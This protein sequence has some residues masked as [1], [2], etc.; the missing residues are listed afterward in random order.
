MTLHKM[1]P[2]DAAWFHMDGPA[3]LAM[4]TSVALTRKPLDFA[5]VKALYAARLSDYPRFRQTGRRTRVAAAGAALGGHAQLRHRPASAPRG[6]AAARRPAALAQLL[7]DIV[8]TPLDRLQPLW[9]V[10]V[11]DGVEGGSALV[12]RFHHC[13][14]DGTAMTALSM[15]LYDTDRR[16]AG[17]PARGR[18][19]EG[20]ARRDRRLVRLGLR[21]P[22]GVGQGRRVD[23]ERG[24]RRRRAPAGPDRQGRADRR[25]RGHAADRT[26]Q[27]RRPR[28]AVQGPVLAGQARRLVGAGGD[29][30]CQ[31]HRRAGRCEG[32]RRARRRHDGCAACLPEGTR[33]RRGADDAARD[34]AGRPA[35]AGARA[36][37][38]QR[39]R[40]RAA[41]TGGRRPDAARAA[42]RDQGAHGRAEAL[43]RAGGDAPAVRHL[44]PHAEAGVRHPLVDAQPARRAWS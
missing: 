23:G 33:C 7:S 19:A 5:K 36:R 32:Q 44:R 30:R 40:P 41:R 20:R 22:G 42:A 16:R 37:A 38:R 15:R 24:A 25:G 34:G 21:R 4:V 28:I 13:I 11:I 31:G 6:A 43:A 17:R 18:G 35:A 27:A 14:G 39:L 10:H 26:A 1:A 12:T 29:R 8:S 9:Q 2:V 3:N